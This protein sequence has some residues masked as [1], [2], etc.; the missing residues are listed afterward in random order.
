MDYCIKKSSISLRRG[1]NIWKLMKISVEKLK[2]KP[3]TYNS[4]IWIFQLKDHLKQTYPV[5]S[6]IVAW[7]NEQIARFEVSKIADFGVWWFFL[8][9]ILLWNLL[10]NMK[11]ICKNSFLWWASFK[12]QWQW[13]ICKDIGLIICEWEVFLNHV[14]KYLLHLNKKLV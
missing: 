3:Q 8:V 1:K 6:R 14:S 11:I 5:K 9:I 12:V 2:R 10:S 13:M 7:V 4:L